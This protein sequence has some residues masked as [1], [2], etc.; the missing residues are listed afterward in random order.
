MWI[1]LLSLA[2]LTWLIIG[3]L[4]VKLFLTQSPLCNERMIGFIVAP[5]DRSQK[6]I[7]YRWE[8]REGCDIIDKMITKIFSVLMLIFF[9]LL[10][11]TVV[12]VLILV[13]KAKEQKLAGFHVGLN[14]PPTIVQTKKLLHFGGKR[15][16]ALRLEVDEI[17]GLLLKSMCEKLKKLTDKDLDNAEKIVKK[18]RSLEKQRL[19]LCREKDRYETNYI[20]AAERYL[21]EAVRRAEEKINSSLKNMT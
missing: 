1:V 4:Y 18:V 6:T 10:T 12:P 5:L 8:T 16:K 13:R 9:L 7:D 3:H 17:D 21:K 20:P 2:I 14:G 19:G 11:V 15:V